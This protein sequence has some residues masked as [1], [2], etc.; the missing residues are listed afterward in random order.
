MYI[1]DKEVTTFGSKCDIQLMSFAVIKN[2]CSV[3]FDGTNVVIVGGKGA[4]FVNGKMVAEGAEC[5]VELYDRIAMGDQ[6]MLFRWTQLEKEGDV[7]MTA[8]DAVEEF[9]AGMMAS[10]AGGG[11]NGD[12]DEERKKLME[13]RTKWEAE[14]TEIGAQRDEEDFQ[15]AMASVDNSILDLLPKAKEAK[16]TVDLLNRTTMTFD[17]V[18]EK[19]ADHIPKVKI[20]VENSAPKLSILIDPNDFLPKLSLLK[21]EMMKLRSA[22]DTGR[23]YVLPERH[24]PL[25]LMFDNDFLLG[26]ATHW[27]EYLLY[28]LETDAEEQQQDIKNAA[29]PYNTVGLLKVEWR[30][31]L[32]TEIE[33]EKDL[34]GKPWK[35]ELLIE[36]ASDLPVYCEQ[37]YVEY[38]FFGETFTTEVIEANSFSPA[39]NYKF[40]HEIAHC[41]QEFVDFLKGSIEMHVHVTQAVDTPKDV[42]GT[43]NEIVVESIKTGTPKGYEA[44]AGPAGG[45]PAGG[46]QVQELKTQLETALSENATLKK[47][48]EELETK[49]ANFE[50]GTVSKAAQKLEEAKLTDSVVN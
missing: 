31:L 46:G 25:F 43:N 18:L 47:K 17:V 23:E 27:P 35:Y 45:A 13:E 26:T 8:E 9:Q 16:Q 14:K 41:T 1:I 20:S 38:D 10:R 2:H 29:V 48:I 37:C 24:D 7:I 34:I 11:D 33:E 12:I 5:K 39:L 50:A 3:K 21:D 49:L 28:N 40:V 36:K 32:D 6:L 19:G 15:R 30:P 42:L 44:A 4:T 22:I